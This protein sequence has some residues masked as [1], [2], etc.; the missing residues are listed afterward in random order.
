MDISL[1]F[2]LILWAQEGEKKGSAP[3]PFGG[4]LLPM[5]GIMI[6]AYFFLILPK[7]RQEKKEREQR[8]ASLK[9]NDKVLLQSGII[10]VISSIKEDSNEVVV[11]LEEGKVRVLKST[12]VNI[13]NEKEEKDKDEKAKDTKANVEKAKDQAKTE[14]QDGEKNT[15]IK[16]A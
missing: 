6:L 9:K 2:A 4:I 10:G 7:Q 12:V 15:A 13:L 11:K 3:S 16:E 5:L 14:N 1:L 8:M